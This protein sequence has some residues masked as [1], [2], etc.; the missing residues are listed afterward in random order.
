V[1]DRER[2]LSEQ[3]APRLGVVSP[4]LAE[5][6]ARDADAGADS[7]PHVPGR[8]VG[9][10]QST[11]LCERRRDYS[12]NDDVWDLRWRWDELRPRLQDWLRAGVYRIGAVRRFPA[13]DETVEVWSAL[14]ALV[15]K[16]TALVLT[17]YW[18]P[19]TSH[20]TAITLKGEA[21]PRPRSGS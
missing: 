1:A 2:V 21:G 9:F 11:W 14:D 8:C 15:L 10:R 6:E 13:G 3:A 16:A 17:A 19:K 4:A 20:P 7:Q 18:L 12:P 5:P